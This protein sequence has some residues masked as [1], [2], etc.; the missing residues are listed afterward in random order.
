[1]SL[2]CSSGWCTRNVELL[3]GLQAP[4]RARHLPGRHCSVSASGAHDRPL[5][6]LPH[7]RDDERDGRIRFLDFTF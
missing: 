4:G 6:V 2:A 3:R 1:M 7:L 5:A